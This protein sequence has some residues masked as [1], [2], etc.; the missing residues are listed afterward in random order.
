MQ[1]IQVFQLIER[2]QLYEKI[3][4]NIQTLMAINQNY[5]D[6]V[7]SKKSDDTR[8]FHTRQVSLYAEYEPTKLMGF[9]RKAGNYNIQEALSICEKKRLPRETVFLCGRSGNGRVALQIILNE[10]KDIEAAI[11]FFV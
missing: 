1:N 3:L 11:E 4:P 10:L 9:L 7:F 6:A 2:K 8:D 5:L